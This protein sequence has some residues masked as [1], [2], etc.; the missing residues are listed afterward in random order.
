MGTQVDFQGIIDQAMSIYVPYMAKQG[1][2]LRFQQDHQHMIVA[3]VKRDDETHATLVVDDGYYTNP[4]VTEDG[5]RFVVCHE[6]GHIV[7]AAPHMEAPAMYDGV[8][9]KNGDLLISA[10]GQ[11]DYFAASKCM[12]QVLADQDNIA[13]NLVHG[14]PP[15]V[16]AKCDQ[17]YPDKQ[18]S[19]LCQRTME[20]GKNFLDSFARSFPS[21]FDTYDPSEPPY[22]LL[23]EHPEAQC[24]LDTVVAGALCPISKDAPVDPYDPTV[25]ACTSRN[26]P[27]GAR[28]RCWFKE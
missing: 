9:D 22:S 25:G 24:R 13:Y 23:G 27:L 20:A 15:V 26:F 3:Y 7:G 17:T 2:E 19:A 14:V 12:R 1:V 18:D 11:A 16:A 4:K 5:F 6:L 8:V 28:P 21:S 10:E